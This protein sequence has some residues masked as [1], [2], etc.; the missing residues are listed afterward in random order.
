MLA[1]SIR[2]A[3]RSP[4]AT[5]ALARDVSL[6]EVAAGLELGAASPR[7]V[8]RNRSRRSAVLNGAYNAGPA[9]T[10]APLRALA[11]LDRGPPHRALGPM[12]ELGPAG[13]AAHRRH[14][15]PRRGGARRASWWRSAP[16]PTGWTRWSTST[17]PSTRSGPWAD[18]AVLVK[19]SRVA[20]LE[21]V[22]ALLLA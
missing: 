8:D 11:H 19:G 10:D 2:W 17:T 13:P 4:A 22:A 14:R 21:R 1:G 3:T 7:R 20:G 18:D 15:G 6:D 12:A 9:S 16:T 5:V